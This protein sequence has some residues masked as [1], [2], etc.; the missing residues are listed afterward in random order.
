[1]VEQ[2]TLLTAL[3]RRLPLQPP[4]LDGVGLLSL[5]ASTCS[6][7]CPPRRSLRDRKAAAPQAKQDDTRKPAQRA[8]WSANRLPVVHQVFRPRDHLG[9]VPDRSRACAS[10]TSSTSFPSG[11]SSVVMSVY[12]LVNGHFAGRMQDANVWPVTYLMLQAVEG[13]AMLFFLIIATLY[14]GE[15]I[16]R[17]RD[18]SFRRHPR[19]AAHARVDRLALANSAAL[20]FVELF[21]LTV[22]LFCG[23]LMPD[24]RRATTTS[25]S[26][27]TSRSFTSSPSPRS[28]SSLCWLSS[29]RRCSA[30]SSSPT[31]S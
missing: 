23:I 17:E 31:V 25:N 7:P 11:P 3:V 22:V 24:H 1:M 9:A 15:L 14:A 29:S 12:V 28:S 30:T 27:S 21:L 16:W 13:S 8:R 20:A 2:N 10:R 18:T 19:R 5:V 6:F 26:S 4:P